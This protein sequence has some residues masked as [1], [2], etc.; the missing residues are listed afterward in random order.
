MSIAAYSRYGV[1]DACIVPLLANAM[2]TR[3]HLKAMVFHETYQ[4]L[5]MK[6][7][8]RFIR[9]IGTA[10]LS[11]ARPRMQVAMAFGCPSFN[12]AER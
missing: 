8:S 3:W 6:S 7:L 12:A 10:A 9:R 2:L 11:A 1:A 5:R 4:L